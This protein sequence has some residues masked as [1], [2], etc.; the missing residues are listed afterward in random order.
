ML[1]PNQTGTPSKPLGPP[2][3]LQEAQGPGSLLNDTAGTQPAL[4]RLGNC[5]TRTSFFG[6]ETARQMKEKEAHL[7]TDRDVTDNH[8]I[9][10]DEPYLDADPNY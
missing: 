7:Q 3:T 9:T 1:A 5:R 2:L 10:I 8:P 6:T 4:P